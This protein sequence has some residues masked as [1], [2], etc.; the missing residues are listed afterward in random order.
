M[1]PYTENEYSRWKYIKRDANKLWVVC[2]CVLGECVCVQCD[3]CVSV[4]LCV[5]FPPLPLANC[6]TSQPHT[7]SAPPPPRLLWLL[8]SSETCWRHFVCAA[9]QSGIVPLQLEFCLREYGFLEC[10]Q[11]GRIYAVDPGNT[12][13]FPFKGTF[14]YPLRTKPE[15]VWFS[16][17]FLSFFPPNLCVFTF[18]ILIWMVLYLELPG[19]DFLEGRELGP[20]SP[21][22]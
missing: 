6:T 4:Y 21:S 12:E 11:P 13:P 22:L 1:S 9:A 14:L 2:M 16:F 5:D 20:T 15:L 17:F 10:S 8:G 18:E 19:G 3:M 7:V